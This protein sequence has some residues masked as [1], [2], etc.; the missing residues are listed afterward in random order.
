MAATINFEKS[1]MF[2]TDPKKLK[3]YTDLNE[4]EKQTKSKGN[5]FSVTIWK[6]SVQLCPDLKRTQAQNFR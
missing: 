5:D 1:T 6:R 4:S 2:G 3:I